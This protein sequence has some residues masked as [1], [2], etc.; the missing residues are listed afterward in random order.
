MADI[1]DQIAVKRTFYPVKQFVSWFRQKQI[2]LRPPFQR[3]DVWKPKAKSFLIDSVLRGL[4]LPIIILRD[5]AGISLEPL[6]EVV[7]GQQRLTTLLSFIEPGAFAASK[8]FTISKAHSR[9]LAGKS[10][11]ELSGDLQ[12]RILDYDLSV[13]LLPTSVDDQ[14]VLRIFS[15]LNAT[16]VRLNDQ[17]LRNAEFQG[18][19]KQFAF[20]LSLAQLPRWKAFKLFTEDDF[21]RMQEVRHTSELI[22]RILKGTSATTKASV[23]KVYRENDG[24]EEYENAV[25]VKNRFEVVLREIEAGFGKD[26]AATNFRRTTWFYTLFG[27]VHDQMF[28]TVRVAASNTLTHVRAREFP[29]AFWA[30]VARAAQL[31]TSDDLPAD[32]IASVTGRTTNLKS[33]LAREAFLKQHLG[34]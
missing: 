11:D 3:K 22:L 12:R 32:V 8:H 17:E 16:G 5:K 6:M 9:E 1:G 30:N 23:D 4:P 21:A 13:H 14:E 24:E 27:E 7:D 26:I 28:G 33:R 20:E 19:F 31:L 10:F 2:Q 18:A 25:E 15:R 34:L 29:H